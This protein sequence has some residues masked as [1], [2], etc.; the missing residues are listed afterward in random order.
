M[1]KTTPTTP[2]LP[3]WRALWRRLGSTVDQDG[4]YGE[5]IAAY[6]HPSRAYHDLGHLSACLAHLDAHAEVAQSADEIELAIWFHDAI[7]RVRRSDNEEKSAEWARA[8]ILEAGLDAAL[9]A[10][11]A[12]LVL[13]TRH[14]SLP[15]DP[16]VRL[17]IDIDLAILGSPPEEFD[18]YEEAVRR[19]YRWV[20]ALL[21]RRKRL[22][23]LESFLARDSTFLTEGIRERYESQ[24]RRNL[25]RSVARLGGRRDPL[26]RERG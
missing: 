15:S 3:R 16:D 10:R 24:A 9:A 22:A 20:P 13:A 5:I 11:V 25:S 1:R 18:R 19:E 6:Q 8:A 21:Y 7:Y 23:I 17:L 14:A 2:D 26:P 12:E 4:L